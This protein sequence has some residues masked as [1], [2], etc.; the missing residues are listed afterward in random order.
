[1][2]VPLDPRPLI[3]N[4]Q[5]ARSSSSRLYKT[6]GIVHESSRRLNACIEYLLEYTCHSAG[7]VSGHFTPELI[8][9]ARRDASPC[10]P[11]F[12]ENMLSFGEKKEN[13]PP[14]DSTFECPAYKLFHSFCKRARKE[15]EV[16]PGKYQVF[17]RSS[18]ENTKGRVKT[19]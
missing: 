10:I 12:L 18:L 8:L 4:A 2:H 6:L 9:S 13:L 5:R 7:I 15:S 17:P 3:K 16:A 11:A 14:P 1:M 19:D